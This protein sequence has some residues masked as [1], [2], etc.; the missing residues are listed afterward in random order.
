MDYIKNG[1]FFRNPLI[2]DGKQ[3]VNPT[4]EQLVEAGW[5]VYEPPQPTEAEQRQDE[6]E[7]L[8]SELAESDYKVIKLAEALA[9]GGDMPYNAL[10]LHSER[11]ALRDRI[12]EL[13]G[14]SNGTEEER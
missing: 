3:I 4:H 14:K 1:K 6:I 7:Q 10:A 11:Q 9:I 13:E 5:Q 2:W 12:N 8:K